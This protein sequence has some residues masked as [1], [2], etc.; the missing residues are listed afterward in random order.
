MGEF[1]CRVF[2][3]ERHSRTRA[4]CRTPIHSLSI[5]TLTEPSHALSLPASITMSATV[6]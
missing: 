4:V 2:L 3:G 6:I 5:A 1:L